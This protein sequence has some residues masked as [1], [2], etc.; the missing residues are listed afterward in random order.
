M[1]TLRLP[2]PVGNIVASR[3]CVPP[4]TSGN[5]YVAVY[6]LSLSAVSKQPFFGLLYFSSWLPSIETGQWK[7]WDPGVIL[8]IPA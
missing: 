7:H 2:F 6:R 1:P 5:V 8:R 3:P 4:A